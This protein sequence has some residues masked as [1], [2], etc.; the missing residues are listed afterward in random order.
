MAI[1]AGIHR[2]RYRNVTGP[3]RQVYDFPELPGLTSSLMNDREI[4]CEGRDGKMNT[5]NRMSSN[6]A[7]YRAE[8]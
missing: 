6:K 2:L 5:F 1:Q 3:L 8:E 7:Q 4:H